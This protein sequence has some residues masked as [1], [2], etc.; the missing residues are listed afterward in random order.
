MHS[1]Q[2][3]SYIIERSWSINFKCFKGLTFI[4]IGPKNLHDLGVFLVHS[5]CLLGSFLVSSW[6]ILGAFLVHSWCLLG[7]F[8][9]PSEFLLVTFWIPSKYPLG[10]FS[11]TFWEPY[12]LFF[13]YKIHKIFQQVFGNISLH[14][15]DLKRYIKIR[16]QVVTT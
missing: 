11:V 8:Y 15:L 9:V 5:W 10:T 3:W 1:A 7:A 2:W 14:T 13:Y 16:R 12:D 4:N 6:F